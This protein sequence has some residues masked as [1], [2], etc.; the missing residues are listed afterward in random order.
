MK[1]SKIILWNYSVP[2]LFTGRLDLDS[3]PSDIYEEVWTWS[4]LKE[5]NMGNL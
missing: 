1:L 3:V 2:I 4:A 5:V